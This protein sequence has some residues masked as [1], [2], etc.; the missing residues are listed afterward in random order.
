MKEKSIHSNHFKS[1]LTDV[2]KYE[3]M[4]SLSRPAP[5]PSH[6]RMP[7]SNR[8]KIFSPFSALRGYEEEIEEEGWKILRVPKK[9]LSEEDTDRLSNLISQI[10]KNMVVQVRYFKEDTL[11]PSIP[12][13]GTYQE[14][15]GTVLQIDFTFHLLHMMH[16]G[17]KVVI[18]FEDLDELLLQP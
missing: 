18:H 16:E 6:P 12:P 2:E 13:L 5:S 3:D 11:H 14:L 1:N 15:T 8:A 10:K 7:V 17:H 9:I 4:M